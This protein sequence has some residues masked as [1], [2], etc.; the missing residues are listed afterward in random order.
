MTAR[1]IGVIGG[2]QLA[3]MMAQVA[4]NLDLELVVQTPNEGDPAISRVNDFVLGAIADSQVT[5]K[6]ANLCDVITFEN[7]FIDLTAL[8][9][10]ADRGVIFRP[11]LAA[12][13]PLLDKYQQRTYLQEI[14]LPVPQF[15][16]LESAT[17]LTQLEI[18]SFPQVL[19]A[20]RNG[21][22]GK[23]T[24]IVENPTELKTIWHKYDCPSMLLEGFVPFSKELA[25]MVARNE[26]G[27][28]A[29]YPVVETIQKEQVCRWVIAPANIP[30]AVAHSAK[31][32]ARTL[33]EKLGY[34]GVLGIEFF[35]T[36]DGNLLINE[37]APRTHNSGHYTLDA[38]DISQFEMQLRAVA[39]LPLVT[40]QMKSAQ[41]LMVNILG[42]E[43]SNHDYQE[44]RAQ[45]SKISQGFLH[46]YGKAESRV[47]RK[48]GHVT[49]LADSNLESP[50]EEIALRIDSLWYP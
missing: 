42:Y 30:K 34:V 46:W 13:A 32:M 26:S 2:G 5:A 24:F 31:V 17:D 9:A 35:L 3:W 44:K 23:G 14:D 40:P 21:Y 10:L 11:S 45:I 16:L 18:T 37:I 27:D 8:Q 6:L 43:N 25:I 36:Q 33:V 47:G 41:A 12:L 49:V 39:D 50:I 1:K 19:K 22:D 29:T 38:C 15:N 48:L 28:I 4:P 20:R 7:E